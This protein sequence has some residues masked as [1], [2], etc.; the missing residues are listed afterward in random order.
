MK[1]SIFTPTHN[2]AYIKELYES[3]KDQDFFEWV[4]VNQNCNIDIKDARI[5]LY[6]LP[7]TGENYV[8]SLKKFACSKCTGDILLEVDHDDILAPTALEEVKK[9]FE[10]KDVGFVYSNTANF[11]D[12]FKKT[13]RYNEAYGWKFRSV[14]GKEC[15]EHVAFKPTPAS[16]SR[17]WYAPNHLRAWRKDVYD[18]IGGHADMRV[19]DDQDLLCR[20]Y[21]ETK[22]KHIDKCLYF[23]RINGLNTWIKYNKEIQD[24]VM[25]IYNK[26]IEKMACK[27]AKDNNLLVLDLGGRFNSPY[28]ETVDLK[29]ADRIMD[30]NKKWDLADGSVGV[31]RAYDVFEHLKDPLHTMKELYRVLADTGYAFIQ[32]PS[33]DGRG[34]WQ[35]PTHVSFWNENSFLY[36]T[37]VTHTKRGVVTPRH[38][39]TAR[40]NHPCDQPQIYMKPFF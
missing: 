38:A 17:I 34:A 20:T 10:D 22:M 13:A 33:T 37:R 29:N 27:W 8:G 15:E 35:D 30:L 9:A 14:D 12:D 40:V 3:I 5:K 23:Y 21:L 19:L 24:N 11:K 1:V 32:V 39:S 6:P 36:Y 18:K 26:Y 31:I 28:G 2:P 7:V 16:V 25:V 4:I